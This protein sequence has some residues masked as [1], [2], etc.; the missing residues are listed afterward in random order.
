V[1]LIAVMAQYNPFAEKAGMKLILKREPHQSISNSIEKLRKLGYN[2]TMLSSRAYNRR[3]LYENENQVDEVRDA[4]LSVSTSYYK[5]LMSCGK[6][7]VKKAEFREWLSKQPL[8]RIGRCQNILSILNQTKAYLY[9]C[10]D[11]VSNENCLN[12][13]NY[14]ILKSR[15]DSFS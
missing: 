12:E 5:R 7:Y 11:W 4:L 8:P 3:K 2:P 15:G 10:R 1:E 14:K 9:W 6:P 13:M